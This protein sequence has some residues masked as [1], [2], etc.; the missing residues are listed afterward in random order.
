MWNGGNMYQRKSDYILAND[1]FWGGKSILDIIQ[2][3]PPKTKKIAYLHKSADPK[4]ISLMPIPADNPIKIIDFQGQFLQVQS[5]NEKGVKVTGWIPI[6]DTNVNY[7]EFLADRLDGYLNKYLTKIDEEIVA[8]FQKN[9]K[10]IPEYKRERNDES[11]LKLIAS[12]REQ[13]LNATRELNKEF[14]QDLEKIYGFNKIFDPAKMQADQLLDKKDRKFVDAR[15]KKIQFDV[16]Y[17]PD[18]AKG[19]SYSN[20]LNMGEEMTATMEVL[21]NPEAKGDP[22][23][24]KITLNYPLTYFINNLKHRFHTIEF[25]GTPTPEQVTNKIG[26][27]AIMIAHE[28]IHTAQNTQLNFQDIAKLP[29]LPDAKEIERRKTMREILAHHHSIF[30]NKIYEDPTADPVFTGTD[31]V[32]GKTAVFDQQSDWIQAFLLWMALDYLKRYNATNPPA[33]LSE[34][35][36]LTELTTDFEALQKD[37]SAKLKINFNLG[38]EAFKTHLTELA[39][40]SNGVFVLPEEKLSKEE[41]EIIEKKAEEEKKAKEGKKAE[42]VLKEVKMGK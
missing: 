22:K 25:F 11:Y 38:K 15:D 10:K 31:F 18:Y 13:E 1:I 35:Y 8:D 12:R 20:F 3:E 36:K 23:V 29:N 16:G 14:M 41:L 2:T 27:M 21:Y 5:T 17:V 37:L 19:E 42:E 32:R 30:P 4:T 40:V 34:K 28:Y 33:S 39:K 26:L 24:D 9:E 6:S 7:N